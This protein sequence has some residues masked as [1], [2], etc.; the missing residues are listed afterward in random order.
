MGQIHFFTDP[1]K[2]NN[3]A[4]DKSYGPINDSQYRVTSLHTANSDFVPCYAVCNGN[5][6]FQIDNTNSGDLLNIILEPVGVNFDGIPVKYFIYRGVKKESVLLSDGISLRSKETNDLLKSVY[7]LT[8]KNKKGA[9]PDFNSLGLCFNS[10]NSS[11]NLKRLDS[12]LIETLFFEDSKYKAIPV[13]LGHVLAEFDKSNFG[14]EIILDGIMYE[15]TLDLVRNINICSEGNT[16]DVTNINSI[17]QKKASRERILY[18]LDPC[19]FFANYYSN[20]INITK[21]LIISQT[22]NSDIIN[23]IYEKI[24]LKFSTKHK[25]Y[26]DI[27]NENNLSLDYYE[28]YGDQIKY[29]HNYNLENLENLEST[30][31]TQNWP[32][33]IFSFSD[34]APLN[35]KIKFPFRI[36]LPTRG[37]L[38][39]LVYLSNAY[40]FGSRFINNIPF[41]NTTPKKTRKFKKFIDIKS[42]EEWT[43]ELLLAVHNIKHKRPL[44]CYIKIVYIKQYEDVN[45]INYPSKIKTNHYL[46]N[47]FPITLSRDYSKWINI[48]PTKYWMFEHEK[49][50][51]YKNSRSE[52]LFSGMYKSGVAIDDNRIIFFAVPVQLTKSSIKIKPSKII[53]DSSNNDTFFQLIKNSNPNI[54]ITKRVLKFESEPDLTVLYFQENESF[55]PESILILSIDK[56]E[57][58]QIKNTINAGN[59]SS[60]FHPIFFQ[61]NETTPLN[62]DKNKIEYFKYKVIVNGLNNQLLETQINLNSIVNNVISKDSFL[63]SSSSAASFEPITGESDVLSIS[64]GHVYTQ[65]NPTIE[66]QNENY[67]YTLIQDCLHQLKKHHKKLYDSIYEKLTVG[68]LTYLPQEKVQK[69]LKYK[70]TIKFDSIIEN[71]VEITNFITGTTTRPP[72]YKKGV[73]SYENNSRSGIKRIPN[74]LDYLN[75]LSLKPSEIA[76]NYI[77]N[78]EVE[79]DDVNNETKII[80]IDK[81][82]KLGYGVI[83]NSIDFVITLNK[84]LIEQNPN[85]DLFVEDSQGLKVQLTRKNDNLLLNEYKYFDKTY[86][87]RIVKIGEIISHELAHVE[88]HI[89]N[90]LLGYLWNLI[91]DN[92]ENGKNGYTGFNPNFGGGHIR[93]NP[94]GNS[95]CS[96]GFL[97]HDNYITEHINIIKHEISDYNSKT[98]EENKVV[99]FV[100]PIL[101]KS[102]KM[103]QQSDS[104]YCKN[105]ID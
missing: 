17:Y 12:D 33:K 15:P 41:L 22:E 93:G 42:N 35:T 97:F 81:A 87:K 71:E 72:A 57:F 77:P 90:S 49:F 50:I 82:I 88:F 80:S 78:L 46:D 85:S 11:E 69:T 64:V 84:Y 25:I 103:E 95:A 47:L 54:E 68:Y 2:L 55:D 92:Y 38:K 24:F 23:P 44:S 39:Q 79:T 5:V 4:E 52:V 94:S 65:N 31:S 14:F 96:S 30:Y 75:F 102:L 101:Y 8:E 43:K 51:E 7:E 89:E 63:I 28:N 6:R 104:F 18:F 73:L 27:R 40:S 1:D 34:D 70:I 29:S 59:I 62:F 74:K 86:N 53:G 37:N 32:I 98:D 105:N 66:Q 20:G 83:D 36:K 10:T 61:I 91:E 16:I 60:D 67:K 3:Q 56:S 100:R 13:N 45:S 76:L 21:E 58:Q 9:I 26:L 99:S 19:A 48:F